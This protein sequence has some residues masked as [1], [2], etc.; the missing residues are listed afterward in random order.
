MAPCPG[1]A[2]PDVGATPAPS[3]PCTQCPWLWPCAQ[4]SPLS[5]VCPSH[6]TLSSLVTA[7][8]SGPQDT[9]ESSAMTRYMQGWKQS[10]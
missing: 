5:R 10:W 8:L 2:M 4:A 9:R 7:C 3:P 6:G 1:V